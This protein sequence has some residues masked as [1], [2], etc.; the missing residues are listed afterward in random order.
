VPAK[1]PREIVQRLNAEAVKALKDPK[2][3]E[4]LRGARVFVIA[5]S[6]EE[7]GAMMRE[8]HAAWGRVI[9]ETGVKGE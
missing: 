7:F 1:T 8:G 9:S 4:M 3:V 2:T 5:N 6:P